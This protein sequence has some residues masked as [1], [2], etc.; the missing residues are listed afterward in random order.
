MVDFNNE[1][2]IGIPAEDIVR[3]IILQKREN[4]HEAIEYY[5]IK[6]EQGLQVNIEPIRFR[7]L[8]LFSEL[9]PYM[10]RI[11]KDDKCEFVNALEKQIMTSKKVDDLILIMHQFNEILDNLRLTRID[12]RQQ[13]DSRRVEEE[14]KAKNL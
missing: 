4:V 2:T 11:K 14:N 8:T 9:R 6:H 3:I 10:K 7:L 12:T 5:F 13:Y 1:H